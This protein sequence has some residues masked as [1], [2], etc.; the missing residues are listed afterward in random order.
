MELLTRTSA[1]TLIRSG[2]E[3]IVAQI[4]NTPLL[5]LARIEEKYGLPESVELHAKA[6]WFNPGGSVKDRAAL[7]MV[8]DGERQG[9]L[10]SGKTILD[11]SSGNTGIA[12]AMIGAALGYRVEICLPESA[13]PERKRLLKLYGATIIDTP[14]AGGTD[15]AII[16]ARR[17]YAE[18]PDRYFYPDQY[19]NPANWQAH[20]Y[21]TAPEIWQQTDGRVTHFVAVVGTS[22]TFMGTSRRLKHYNPGIR[23]VEVQPDAAFHGLEGMKHMPSALVPGIYDPNLADD[24]LE[25]GTE[26]AQAMT[27]DL[28][29]YEGILAGPSGGAGVLAAVG[30]AQSLRSGVVVTVLPDGGN[31][32]LQDTFWDESEESEG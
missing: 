31:R 11:A 29:R 4:G 12:Y 10:T 28:A 9:L 15:G 5:R 21:G 18:H 27:R 6:E 14:P 19:N 16:E 30:V 13:S 3:D 24:N 1:S 25:V 22:G 17:R 20:Y 8:R 32:Y 2:R 26:E 7:Y 23:I